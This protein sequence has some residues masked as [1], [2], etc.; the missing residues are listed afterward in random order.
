MCQQVRVRYSCGHRGRYLGKKLC[1][2]AQTIETY[3]KSNNKITLEH[4]IEYYNRECAKCSNEE[5]LDR[6]RPCGACAAEKM[7]MEEEELEGG[8]KR[9]YGPEEES[10]EEDTIYSWG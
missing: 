6:N 4:P 7:R 2:H 10:E 1:A 9:I 3:N 8:V 5:Y